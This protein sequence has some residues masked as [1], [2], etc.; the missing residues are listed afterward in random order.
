MRV[1]NRHHRI[2]DVAPE[3]AGG[4]IDTLST[5]GDRLWPVEE[6][7]ALR[8]DR[9]LGVGAD[10]GHGPVRYHVESYEPGR[11]VRFR[12]TAPRGFDGFHE[13]TLRTT[14]TGETELAHLMVLRLRHPAW[15]TYPLLW[16]P[17][18]DALLEDCL[19][20]AERELTGTV[21]KPARWSPYVR[22]LR[23]LISGRRPFRLS[24]NK[25]PPM[26]TTAIR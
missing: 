22:L 11:S 13:F 23:S 3:R 10:G 21:G 7:P 6:W 8:F 26:S 24:R 25:V 18:H 16:R 2:I 4:L 1:W 19:D 14:E 12:F 9:P 20:R 15:F 17:M 5:D